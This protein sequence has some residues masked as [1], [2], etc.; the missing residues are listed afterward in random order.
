MKVLDLYSGAGGLSFGFEMTN[1]FEVVGGIDIYP[2]ALESFYKNHSCSTFIESKYSKPTDLS[3]KNIRHEIA[4]DFKGVDVIVG[5]PPCQGFSVAGKRL[6]DYLEDPRNHQVFYFYDL[7]EKIKPIAFVMENVRG[8]GHTGQSTKFDILSQLQE[9]FN[10]IGYTS[11]FKVLKS[12]DFFVPQK[13][14]RMFLVGVLEGAQNFKFPTPQTNTHENLFDKKSI[15]TVREAIDDLPYPNNG[16]FIKYQSQAN[17]WYQK[18]MREASEGVTSHFITRHGDEFIERIK[19]Q[20]IG[21]PLFSTWNHSWVKLDP[22]SIAPTIKE[23]H[24]APG[25]HYERPMS[26]STRECARLQ[27]MPDRF[28]LTGTKSQSLVQVGNAVPPLLGAAVATSLATT[29]GINS[30]NRFG[31]EH[32]GVLNAI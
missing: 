17:C 18:L 16:Q 8:I 14:R 27:S 21:K 2:P 20:K 32:H 26:I 29:L 28:Y 25:I 12:E 30:I 3:C 9:K 11:S 13:R 6:D 23:N 1:A 24:R 7:V 5:G 10:K 19:A 4:K 31:V 15:V 22:N